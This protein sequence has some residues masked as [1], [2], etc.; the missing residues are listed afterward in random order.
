[1]VVLDSA[2]GG[3]PAPGAAQGWAGLG[4]FPG[5]MATDGTIDTTGAHWLTPGH[6][7]W[8]AH[9]ACVDVGED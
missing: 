5:R 3:F 8:H 9:P 7:A 1:M 4:H 2:T 6:N